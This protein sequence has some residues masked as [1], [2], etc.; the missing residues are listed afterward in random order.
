MKS[1]TSCRRE[2]QAYIPNKVKRR[3]QISGSDTRAD[4]HRIVKLLPH[5]WLPIMWCTG[6]PST[7]KAPSTSASAFCRLSFGFFLQHAQLATHMCSRPFGDSHQHAMAGCQATCNLQTT[8][9][10]WQKPSSNDPNRGRRT[11]PIDKVAEVHAKVYT[12]VLPSAHSAHQTV[13]AVSV[14][15][16][17]AAVRLALPRHV[18]ISIMDVTCVCRPS[19]L[20]GGFQTGV[21]VH[22]PAANRHTARLCTVQT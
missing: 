16:C 20:H 4:I 8:C 22:I 13:Q 7:L 1:C 3:W 11:L 14:V 2:G 12:T 18:Q 6:L 5:Q 9:T 19:V 17:S 10:H 15:P 21:S